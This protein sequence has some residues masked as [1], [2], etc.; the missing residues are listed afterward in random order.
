MSHCGN[1]ENG[2]NALCSR[3]LNNRRTG[4]DATTPRTPGLLGHSDS[5]ATKLY[6][7]YG[8]LHMELEYRRVV[9]P[10]NSTYSPES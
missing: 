6:R 7:D 5:N 10:L 4:K 3:Y 8:R 2:R 1:D 9:V